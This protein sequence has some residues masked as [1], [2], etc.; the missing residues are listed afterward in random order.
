MKKT[1][2]NAFVML[3][4]L[5]AAIELSPTMAV[6][7]GGASDEAGTIR[8]YARAAGPIGKVAL[9]FYS[10][11][12]LAINGREVQGERLLWGGELLQAPPNRSVLVSFDSIGQVTLTRGAVVRF[13]TSRGESNGENVPVLVASLLAGDIKVRLEAQAGA[14]VRAADSAFA[15]T[16]GSSF[17]IGINEGQPVIDTFTGSVSAIQQPAQR[18]YLVR[19]VGVGSNISVRVRATR[20]IQVQVTD[21]NDRP[22]PDLPII[23]LLDGGGGQFVGSLT[24]GTSVTVRTDPQ[25]R[26][27]TTFTAGP[28]SGLNTITATVEGTSYSWTGNINVTQIGFWTVRNRLIV[29]G[30]AAAAAGTGVAVSAAG[31]DDEGLRPLPPPDVR[32]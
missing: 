23:F 25:G 14:F 10:K 22:V 8:L 19:P 21:E 31:D 1:V 26:A 3:M 30:A 16:S 9:N 29:V 2:Y 11:S 24:G 17:R 18:K 20:Q 15:A 32:P 12:A 5:V 6:A 7:D 27:S 4:V 13:V 28:T